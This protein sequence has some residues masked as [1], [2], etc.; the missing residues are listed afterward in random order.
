M[1]MHRV[2]IA[3]CVAALLLTPAAHAQEPGGAGFAEGEDIGGG[4]KFAVY[5]VETWYRAHDVESRAKSAHCRGMLETARA[6]EDAGLAIAERLRSDPAGQTR[7]LIDQL[8]AHMKVRNENLRA[9]Q[10]CVVEATRWRP[11]DDPERPKYY[12]GRP[13]P[14]V[15]FAQGVA[16]GITDGFKGDRVSYL[17]G[18]AAGRL[19]RNVRHVG[20]ALAVLGTGTAL[21][22]A[23]GQIQAASPGMDHWT[24]GRKLG[25][26]VYQGL[27]VADAVHNVAGAVRRTPSTGSPHAGPSDGVPVSA[28]AAGGT[29]PRAVPDTTPAGMPP[30][31]PGPDGTLPAGAADTTLAAAAPARA[32]AATA[33]GPP[34]YEI[35]PFIDR[36]TFG[37]VYE[38]AG[39]PDKV[40]KEVTGLPGEA[41]ARH[42]GQ[43]NGHDLVERANANLPAGA[44]PIP[45]AAILDHG[46][47]AD[48]S[49][50]MVMEHVEQ[51]GRWKQ[52]GAETVKDA[53]VPYTPAQAEAVRNLGD[54][55]ADS[56]L[57]W[58][59]P[60]KGNV[61]FF[62]E[63]GVL[64]AG[65]LDHDFIYTREQAADIAE[66]TSRALSVDADADEMNAIFES[67]PHEQKVMY[68]NVSLSNRSMEDFTGLAGPEQF[69]TR[70]FMDA[71]ANRH[72]FDGE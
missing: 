42:Q 3:G 48:G 50:W 35:G 12:Y 27:S 44:E 10:S 30:R 29:P 13:D 11:D 66:A 25:Q 63:N 58:L 40:F 21:E 37:S 38:V 24:A 14:A 28:S 22:D 43:V 45:Q 5:G 54:Q 26:L 20:T 64:K 4:H 47:P 56:H 17:V 41:L 18:P 62:R 49:P 34:G 52:L 2:R 39:H 67:L 6:E 15:D 7:E 72:G 53:S 46:V 55:L 19:L 36:G 8:N 68:Y 65:V 60:N 70:A 16:Q 57:V 51:A 1:L 33:R 31:A 59:D 9:F 32:V 69:D 71:M 23:I 61:F